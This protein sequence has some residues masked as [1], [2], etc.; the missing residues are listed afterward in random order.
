M[1]NQRI[2]EQASEA[3]W[4]EFDGT[5]CSYSGTYEGATL[6][7]QLAAGHQGYHRHGK[8]VYPN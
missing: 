1:S 3:L 5:G 2:A 8:L 4:R 6:H 7:C